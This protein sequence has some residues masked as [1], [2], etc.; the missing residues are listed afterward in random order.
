MRFKILISLFLLVVLIIS[1]Q[2]DKNENKLGSGTDEKTMSPQDTF[3]VRNYSAGKI[4]F[5]TK[6]AACHNP[7]M[8]RSTGP[9]LQCATSRMPGGNW[10]YEYVRN[11]SKVLE[12][13]DAYAATVAKQNNYAMMT[14]FNLSNKEIDDIFEWIDH[15]YP[16]K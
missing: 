15:A 4:L 10:R 9:G 2:D 1:C 6:C 13:G 8:R 16:C 12:S 14:I 7:D 3:V 11:A 5:K